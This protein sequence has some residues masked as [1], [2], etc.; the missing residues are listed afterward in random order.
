MKVT[1]LE[2]I[3]SLALQLPT[4]D[5]C[6]LA[7]R[8]LTSLSEEDEVLA[9]WVEEAERRCEAFDRGEMETVSFEESIA[10]LRSKLPKAA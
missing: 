7:E 10:R 9:A 2:E 3:E 1:P 6:R 4:A 5:R 8:L